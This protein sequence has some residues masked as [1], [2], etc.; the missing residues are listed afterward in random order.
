MGTMNRDLLS[1]RLSVKLRIPL[2][3]AR[4][5]VNSLIARLGEAL[6][7]DEEIKIREFGTFGTRLRTAGQGRNSRSGQPYP[8]SARRVVT[9]KPGKRLREAIAQSTSGHSLPL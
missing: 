7:A 1:K 3:L 8:I 5:L 6:Q 9:F 4:S 2:P